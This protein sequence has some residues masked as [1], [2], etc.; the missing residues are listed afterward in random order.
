MDDDGRPGAQRP[1]DETRPLAFD[2]ARLAPDPEPAV[3]AALAVIER[4]LSAMA[5]SPTRPLLDPP[6][7]PFRLRP[8]GSTGLAV[9]PVVLDTRLLGT[10]PDR[11]TAHRVLDAYAAIGGNALVVDDEPDGQAAQTVGTWLAA[12]RRR[13][14]VVLAGRIGGAGLAAGQVAAAVERL[15][16]RLGTER[17]DLVIAGS[18][19]SASLQ[20]TL[21]ALAGSMDRDRVAHVVAG[22]H[23]AAALIRARVLAGQRDLPRFAAVSP[24]YN[25]LQRDPYETQTA[26]AVHA[27]QLSCLPASPLAG[28]FLAAEAPTRAALKRLRE[29]HPHRAERL[30]PLYT[31][32]GV[33]VLEAVVQIAAEREVPPA[34]VALAWLLT[35]P[36]VAAPVVA[37][38]SVEE[39][40]SAGAAASLHLSRAEATALQRAG[41]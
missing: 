2:A 14:A 32:R 8:V 16:R 29:L 13:D 38:A 17:L 1:G 25:L 22:D 3:A 24:R 30:Q 6:T 39:V 40:W 26:A 35:R 34:A 31:R 20:E 33:R 15:L 5:S 37:A 10:A 18:D 11:T 21:T 19:R 12:R 41:E 9:F 27:Q 36:H 7:Q 4:S 23:D 28:G